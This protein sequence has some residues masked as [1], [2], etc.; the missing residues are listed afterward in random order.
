MKF[1]IGFIALALSFNAFA[2]PEEHIQN[3]SCYVIQ[4][5]K[6]QVVPTSVPTEI[7]LEDIY[8]SAAAKNIVVFSYFQAELWKDLKLDQFTRVDDYQFAYQASKDI[9]EKWEGS[10]GDGEINTLKVSGVTDI[11]GRG[12]PGEVKISVSHYTTRDNCHTEPQEDGTY[13]YS[14]R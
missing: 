6:N 4:V 11:T 8:V 13:Q 2:G 3:Q 1:V 5:S 7:C 10:C 9:F 12:T 14:L